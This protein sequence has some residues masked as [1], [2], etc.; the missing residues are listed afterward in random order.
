MF[1]ATPGG[2]V[3]EGSTG[4][5]K[6]SWKGFRRYHGAQVYEGITEP[7][8]PPPGGTLQKPHRIP[9]GLPRDTNATQIMLR[10]PPYL[11][12]GAQACGPLPRLLIARAQNTGG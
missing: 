6:G 7:P 2:G 3:E 10:P 1:G 9:N 4:A 5:L 8:P 11:P 12:G